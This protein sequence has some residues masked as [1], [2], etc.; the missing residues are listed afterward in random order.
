MTTRAASATKRPAVKGGAAT[1]GPVAAV[2]NLLSTFDGEG[3]DGGDEDVEED[4]YCLVMAVVC[5]YF[6]KYSIHSKL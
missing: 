2:A 4:A 3:G 1:G 5:I 6:I